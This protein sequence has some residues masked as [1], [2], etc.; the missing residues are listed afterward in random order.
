MLFHEHKFYCIEI[1]GSVKAILFEETS[2]RFNYK[3][4]SIRQWQKK[5]HLAQNEEGFWDR[6]APSQTYFQFGLQRKE[7]AR[8]VLSIQSKSRNGL[9]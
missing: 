8:P 2:Y 4:T 6:K 5:D 1:S 7:K 9:I 3:D